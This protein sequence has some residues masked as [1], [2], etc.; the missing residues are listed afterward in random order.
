MKNH[1]EGYVSWNFSME[2]SN[3]RIHFTL[4]CQLLFAHAHSPSSFILFSISSSFFPLFFDQNFSSFSLLLLF[5]S[6]SIIFF[7]LHLFLSLHTIIVYQLLF[8]QKFI[9]PSSHGHSSIPFH[10]LIYQFLAIRSPDN[11][12]ICPPC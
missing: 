11:A 10:T 8:A 4:V 3:W 5:L 7:F 9:N 1:D 2:N 6:L 12:N